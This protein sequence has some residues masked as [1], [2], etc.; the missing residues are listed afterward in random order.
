[1]AV[2]EK[3]E[4]S[5]IQYLSLLSKLKPKKEELIE[6]KAP[7]LVNKIRT[8][9]SV[10]TTVASARRLVKHWK[11][12]LASQE[13][14]SRPEIVPRLPLMDY[15]TFEVH[16]TATNPFTRISRSSSSS[17]RTRGV[18]VVP[19]LVELCLELLSHHKDDLRC[20]GDVP[21]TLLMPILCKYSWRQLRRIESF[22]SEVFSEDTNSLWKMH[23][24]S[25]FRQASQ[26]YTGEDHDWRRLFFNLLEERDQT[27]ERSAKKVG[28]KFLDRAS[29]TTVLLEEKPDRVL[30][31]FTRKRNSRLS[32]IFEEVRRFSP[33]SV[34]Q[35]I[36]RRQSK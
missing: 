11:S 23:V 1:M 36:I 4:Q 3:N 14:L 34:P 20:V 15:S 16:D 24:T 27:I 18:D 22:N 5:I 31:P 7:I 30:N 13:L 17:K 19:S 2:S 8:W 35:N 28:E 26:H 33:Y 12:I 32:H 10:E 21:A 25:E 29:K 6:T 9:S